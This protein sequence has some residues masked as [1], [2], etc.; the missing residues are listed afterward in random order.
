MHAPSRSSWIFGPVL[1]LLTVAPD[2]SAWVE[3]SVRSDVVVLEIEK[4]GSAVVRHEILMR[5]RGGPFQGFDLDGVDS[6]AEPLPDATVVE[7]ASGVA[8]GTPLPVLAEKRDGG[9][10]R[11]EVDQAKGLRRGDYLFRV[12]YRSRFLERNLVELRG[13]SAEIHWVGPRFPDGIDSAKVVFRLPSAPR[14]PEVPET[15]AER[16]E[17][18]LEELGGVFLSSLHRNADKDELEVVRPHVAKGEPVVWKAR[19]DAKA[20]TAFSPP[21]DPVRVTPETNSPTVG[22]PRD[23]LILGG[24]LVGVALAYSLLVLAKWRSLV[25][26]CANTSAS[27]R[28]L[29][30]LNP[31]LRAAL[32]GATLAGAITSAIALDEARL[33]GLLLL[34]SMALASHLTPEIKATPRGPGKWLPL[35]DAEAF[36]G[37][38][39]KVPGRWLDATSFPGFLVFLAILAGFAWGTLTLLPIRPYWALLLALGSASTI[40][41]F[42]T[43]RASELPL[44]PVR[45]PQRLLRKLSRELRKSKGLKVVAWARMPDGS[46]TPDELR[47]LVLPRPSRV[48]LTAI[49]VGA[50]Y[51]HEGGGTMTLPCLLVRV[52]EGSPAQA[53]LEGRVRWTR[54]KKPEERVAVL[55]PKLPTYSLLLGLL[56]RLIVTLTDND[57]LRE[58]PRVARRARAA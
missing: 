54:G 18:G 1:A 43:G 10:L 17:L 46:P 50:E 22:S 11:L 32:S 15:A 42:L 49:E 21:E 40:P 35:A 45:A 33:G 28:A 24:S 6:D 41:L 47:L 2:A 31:A 38:T 14:A 8:G 7:A 57:E 12:A 26:A 39:P 53:A 20:F 27:P 44:N 51:H 37:S 13:S 9:A 56:Q 48:G 23:R 52:V 29:L 5:V 58:K 36:T 3:S 34:A 25:K 30:R 19:A 4:D 16:G 55:R